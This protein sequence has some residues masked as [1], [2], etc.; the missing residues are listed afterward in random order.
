MMYLILSILVIVIAVIGFQANNSDKIVLYADSFDFFFTCLIY[1]IPLVLA[2]GLYLYF[3][4]NIDI[5]KFLI[6]EIS[7]FTGLLALNTYKDNRTVGRF[8]LAFI[9]RISVGLISVVISI[10]LILCFL[11]DRKGKDE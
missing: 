4:D 6:I 2:L 8:L 7:G 3:G 11:N 5:V 10:L 1:I 9:T